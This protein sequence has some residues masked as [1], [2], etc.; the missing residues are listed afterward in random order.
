MSE[1]AIQVLQD[2]LK[3]NKVVLGTF[4]PALAVSILKDAGM[5]KEDRRWK[6]IST[7][8]DRDHVLLLE[9]LM[10]GEAPVECVGYKVGEVFKYYPPQDNPDNEI[11]PK[12]IGW[13]PLPEL[14]APERKE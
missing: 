13:Y 11:I 5:L 14:S 12:V 2:Y 1:Q 4:S 6:P 9:D 7:L 8:G 10:D 3:K